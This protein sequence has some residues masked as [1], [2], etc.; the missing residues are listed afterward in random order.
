MV[1]TQVAGT[2]TVFLYVVQRVK[3]RASLDC[4]FWASFNA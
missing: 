4:S 2:E 3:L 1:W